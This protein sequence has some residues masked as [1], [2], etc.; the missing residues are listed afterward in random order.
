MKDQVFF[1]IIVP[2]Y[3]TEQYLAQCINSIKN[4]TFQNF[5]VIV[6]DDGSPSNDIGTANDIVHSETGG[7]NRFV[8][9]TNKNQGV[10][11]ARNFALS[12]CNGEFVLFLDSDDY[13]GLKHL[14]NIYNALLIHKNEWQYSIFYLKNFTKVTNKTQLVIQEP[15]T[16]F[17]KELVTFSIPV[18]RLIL[19]KDLLKNQTFPNFRPH[20]EPGLYLKIAFDFM[21]KNKK[22]I[23]FISIDSPTYHY[24]QR[25]DSYTHQLERKNS[26]YSETYAEQAYTYLLKTCVVPFYYK[27]I[28]FFSSKRMKLYQEKDLFAAIK[29]KMYSFLAKLLSGWYIR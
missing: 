28:I 1:S 2:V 10:S 25:E 16:F 22:E 21:E 29:R 9:Y 15:Q 18:M 23:H 24:Y 14:E 26:Y 11:E 3:N 6:V 7:D 27:I 12:K 20:E 17:K 4:Q 8:V 13:L 19:H 5:E